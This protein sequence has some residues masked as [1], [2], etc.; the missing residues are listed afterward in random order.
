MKFAHR[1][2]TYE[3][4][5][6]MGLREGYDGEVYPLPLVESLLQA[7]CDAEGFCVTLEPTEF[8]YTS[9]NEPGCVIG[10]IN[11]PRFPKTKADLQFKA[12]EIAHM[13]LKETKQYR[14]SVVAS[15]YTWLLENEDLVGNEGDR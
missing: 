10:I 14:C 2:D 8:I 5:I 1:V 9:G 12:F 3:I 15:D 6:Y 13:L 4:K 7:Y 11:Y